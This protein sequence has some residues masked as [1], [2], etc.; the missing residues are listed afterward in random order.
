MMIQEW[1][2]LFLVMYGFISLI[3]TFCYISLL[4]TEKRLEDKS[5]FVTRLQRGETLDKN[6]IF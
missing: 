4:I 2:Y 3:F 6:N 5:D 1:F